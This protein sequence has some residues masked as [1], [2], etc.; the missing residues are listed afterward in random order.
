M[1]PSPAVYTFSGIPLA[2]AQVRVMIRRWESSTA[3]VWP[4][5]AMKTV[6]RVAWLVL[7]GIQL[8]I[9]LLWSMFWIPVA[10]LLRLLTGSARLPLRMAA[11]LWSPVLIHGAGA[12]IRIEGRE[13]VDFSRPHVFVANHQSMIDICALFSA[14]PVPLR[15]MLKAELGRLPFL[16]WY[17]RAMGMV[18]VQRGRHGGVRAQIRQAADLLRHGHSLCGFPEGTR[19]P[20][21]SVGPFK[22]GLFS[23][24]IDAG[25]AVVPIAIR[26]T[27]QVMPI[28]GFHIRPGLI[29]VSFGQPIET[30]VLA[31]SDRR[32]LAE[33]V[34]SELIDLLERDHKASAPG[35]GIS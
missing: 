26:G 22:N 6:K 14:V 15:F 32:Q 9:T 2:P 1:F 29:E 17:T 12:R 4:Q 33:R 23:A 30:D 10:L 16:G 3:R 8:L 31:P 19:S 18:P 27:G 21:G 20:D 28:G 35:R 5:H 13:R 25:V 34:R 24:A 7:N 11:W